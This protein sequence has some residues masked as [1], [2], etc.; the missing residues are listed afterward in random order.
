MVHEVHGVHSRHSGSDEGL[1]SELDSGQEME[2]DMVEG[3][4]V[5]DHR[6]AVRA[7][8]NALEKG[9]KQ[10]TRSDPDLGSM[11][12]SIIRGRGLTSTGLSLKSQSSS[13][14]CSSVK[15]L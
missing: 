14:S 1:E 11:T 7:D 5:T 10:D 8:M 15:L 9:G 4:E 13:G 6:R 2:A 3:V 12:V